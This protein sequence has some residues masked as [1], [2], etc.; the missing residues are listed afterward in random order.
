MRR[1]R[2]ARPA[3]SWP[4]SR[5][6]PVVVADAPVPIGFGLDHRD[7]SELTDLVALQQAVNR[8]FDEALADAGVERLRLAA[9]QHAHGTLATFDRRNWVMYRQPYT[10]WFAHALGGSIAE[11]VGLAHA[12]AT[13]GA[14]ARL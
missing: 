9:L 8:R 1:L 12:C 10:D 2:S 11:L 4:A 7:P 5:A 13:Q 6:G 14:R 3:G